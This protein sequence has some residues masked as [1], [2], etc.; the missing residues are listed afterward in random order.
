MKPYYQDA[1]VTIYHGDAIECFEQIAAVDSI[2]M[3]PPYCSGAFTEAGRKGASGM[4]LSHSVVKELGWFVGDNMGTAGI[5]WLLRMIAVRG[6]SILRE[7]G[8]CCCFTD[9]RMIANIGPAI[10]SS[11][12][13]WQNII[14][15]DKRAAGMGNG[16]RAQHEMILHYVKGTGDYHS[17]SYGN[18]L[19]IP[20]MNYHEREHQTQK[21]VEL[22]ECLVEVTTP[23]NGIVLDPFCG[24]GS[25]LR[26]AKNQGRRAIG[27][28]REE[29]FCE[30]GAK[31]MG[32]EILAFEAAPSKP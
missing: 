24:S 32:Q 13:R 2:L 11:G 20:R 21:P 14:V 16:F 23:R 1:T 29:R 9:W 4:G 5:A 17:K 8:S 18:V 15:W 6:Y 12:F 28:E 10:E 27:F 25:T 19:S 3:D 26:A 7:G 30:I 22:M 31:R